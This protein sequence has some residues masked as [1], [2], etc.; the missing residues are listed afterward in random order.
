MATTLLTVYG[1]DDNIINI[2]LSTHPTPTH[3][4]THTN[5]DTCLYF[6]GKLVML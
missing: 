6:I 1:I 2:A 4:H 3:V 5:V